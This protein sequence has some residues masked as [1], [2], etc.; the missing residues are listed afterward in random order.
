MI[1]FILRIFGFG[2]KYSVKRTLK[3]GDIIEVTHYNLE[4]AL[5][6]ANEFEKETPNAN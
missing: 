3:N 6:I 1:E 5:K 2:T 4:K